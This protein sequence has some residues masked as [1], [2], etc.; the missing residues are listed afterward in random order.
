MSL[1]TRIGAWLAVLAVCVLAPAGL[2]AE[3]E[4]DEDRW[5]A[6]RFDGQHAGWYREWS[7]EDGERITSRSRM[8]L[9]IRRGR[10]TLKIETTNRFVET[11]EGEAISASTTQK[12]GGSTT[13]KEVTFTED[14]ARMVIRRDGRARMRRIDL[15]DGDWLTPADAAAH[16]KERIEAGAKTIRYRTF[17]PSTAAEPYEVVIR[18]LGREDIEVFGR[19]VPAIHRRIRISALPN[20]KMTEYIDPEDGRL[21]RTTMQMG[22]MRLEL[23]AADK[24]LAK[25]RVDPPELLASTLIEPDFTIEQPRR[26]REATYRLTLEEG[27]LPAIPESAVQRV[28]RIDERTARLMIDLDRPAGEAAGEVAG[29]GPKIRHTGMIDGEDERVA[30]LAAKAARTA[31]G[32][33]AGRVAE[34]MRRFVRGHVRTEDLS[35]G[36]ASASEVARTRVGDCT[37]HAVLLAAM[38]QAEGIPA[39]VA[40]GLI[41]VRRFIGRRDVFGYHMWTQAWIDGR[42]VDLDATRDPSAPFDAA[43]ILLSASRLEDGR[44]DND[45]MTLSPLIGR[46]R[47]ERLDGGR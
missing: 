42:W 5:Y 16:T 47:I 26:L 25:A 21:L 22:S 17:E 23:V 39:R 36:L 30:E 13:E 11:A 44:V 6:V 43:H 35:V 18:V 4:E 1:K 19:T 9:A 34:A 33:D 15:S 14:G 28:E 24:E 3:S 7:T 41:Y 46:L 20:T 31:P 27:E 38:L 32:D 29:A 12:V 10:T 2:S 45:L 37:E 8:H 40:S